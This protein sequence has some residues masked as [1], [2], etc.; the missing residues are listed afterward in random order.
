MKSTIFLRSKASL[1][2][3]IIRPDEFDNAP[4]DSSN[5]SASC[6]LLH[7]TLPQKG[8]FSTETKVIGGKLSDKQ[9]S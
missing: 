6:R 3:D 2:D 5:E 1:E 4:R 9:K 7:I 8:I